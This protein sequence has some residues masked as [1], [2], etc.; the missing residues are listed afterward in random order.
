MTDIWKAGVEVGRPTLIGVRRQQL[1]EKPRRNAPCDRRAPARARSA[2]G[3]DLD[4]QHATLR[5]SGARPRWSRRTSRSS[6]RWR[7]RGVRS[8]SGIPELY[9]SVAA[10]SGRAWL[11]VVSGRRIRP[12]LAGVRN[13]IVALETIAIASAALFTAWRLRLPRGHPAT[14]GD[15]P[16][17]PDRVRRAT[18]AQPRGRRRFFAI[19]TLLGACRRC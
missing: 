7:R 16:A 12:I 10:G 11:V 2:R 18:G 19:L 15:R 1:P 3:R 5:R 8:S 9:C 13:F 17:L 14:Y 6:R 4:D